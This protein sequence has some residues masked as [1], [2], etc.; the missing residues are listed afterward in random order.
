VLR[1]RATPETGTVRYGVEVAIAGD[2][3]NSVSQSFRAHRA[4]QSLAEMREALGV[5]QQTTRPKDRWMID[6]GS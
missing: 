6:L 1:A 5:R 4:R 2:L 3:E